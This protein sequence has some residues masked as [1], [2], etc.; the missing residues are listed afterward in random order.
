MSPSSICPPRTT[1]PSPLKVAFSPGWHIPLC[2][3]LSS[4]HSS[5]RD[6]VMI[7]TLIFRTGP[8]WAA[9]PI[10]FMLTKERANSSSPQIGH[11]EIPIA[12]EDNRVSEHDKVT[13][14]PALQ[15]A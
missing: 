14:N 1:V 5:S 4:R 2:C 11:A 8:V 9:E 6:R 13:I 3:H 12:R 10:A 7:H 15:V